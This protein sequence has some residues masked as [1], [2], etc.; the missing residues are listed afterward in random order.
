MS[1]MRLEPPITVKALERSVARAAGERIRRGM[2]VQ[3]VSKQGKRRNE[4]EI[5]VSGADPSAADS[6]LVFD[7]L[8]LAANIPSLSFLLTLF[9]SFSLPF[10]YT[11]PE[12]HQACLPNRR[13]I[14]HHNGDKRREAKLEVEQSEQ[15][16]KRVSGAVDRPD[17]A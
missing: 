9:Q 12:W 14:E 17:L 4:R 5:V 3:I 15:Q 13:R 10:L 11:R 16:R 2:V 7:E 8:N 1:E 6:G